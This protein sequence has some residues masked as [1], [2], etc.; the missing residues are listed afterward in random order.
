ML[1]VGGHVVPIFGGVL[2]LSAADNRYTYPEL[3]VSR[4]NSRGPVKSGHG[5]PTRPV[6]FAS[7]VKRHDLTCEAWNTP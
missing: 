3:F 1:L 2:G 4:I 7:L 5:Y 6:T